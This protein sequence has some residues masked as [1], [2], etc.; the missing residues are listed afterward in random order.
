MFGSPSILPVNMLPTYE[1][2][3]KYYT[4][5]K[6]DLKLHAGGKEP[7][8]TE[9]CE[10]V[11]HEVESI[12]IRVSIP[13]V[14]HTQAIKVLRS[15]HD[16]YLKLLKSYKVRYKLETYKKQVKDFQT[17]AKESLFDIASCKC[18]DDNKCKCEKTRKVPNDEKPFLRDQ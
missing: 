7:R 16:K 9:I 15:Y 17:Q 2:V 1:C 6:N 13:I 12:W 3:M 11:T 8:V 4:C 14:S 10:T 5:V 18:D